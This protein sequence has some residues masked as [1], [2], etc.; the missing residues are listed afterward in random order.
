ML[1]DECFLKHKKYLR[2]HIFIFYNKHHF[3]QGDISHAN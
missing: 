2:E 1:I 3:F